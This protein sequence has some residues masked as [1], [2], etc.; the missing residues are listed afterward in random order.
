MRAARR[1]LSKNRSKGSRRL[2]CSENSCLNVAALF[3][4]ALI[5]RQK[6]EI[7]SQLRS[8]T[9]V[10]SSLSTF[11]SAFYDRYF[12]DSLPQAFIYADGFRAADWK[13]AEPMAL[14]TVPAQTPVL[15]KCQCMIAGRWSAG[16]RAC[17]AFSNPGIVF[18]SRMNAGPH[19]LQF[20]LRRRRKQERLRMPFA[21]RLEVSSPFLVPAVNRQPYRLL[22]SAWAY[23]AMIRL[24]Q[25]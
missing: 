7:N 23:H 12:P 19:F 10:A 6:S 14:V 25:M 21:E 24:E 5:D 18:Q 16:L 13:A 4:R 11:S 2:A 20:V 1:R 9:Q 17:K 22:H 3:D 15:G 8:K